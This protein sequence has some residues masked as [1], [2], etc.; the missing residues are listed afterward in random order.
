VLARSHRCNL[1]LRLSCPK[2]SVRMSGAPNSQ[3]LPGVAGHV[4]ISEREPRIASAAGEKKARGRKGRERWWGRSHRRVLR[5]RPAGLVSGATP[6]PT[7]IPISH[8][9][10]IAFPFTGS[11]RAMSGSRDTLFCWPSVESLRGPD[12]VSHSLLHGDAASETSAY[13]GPKIAVGQEPRL[14]A[15]VCGGRSPSSNGGARQG[16]RA[17]APS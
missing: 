4:E 2:K 15:G 11:Q 1:C 16:E 5:D 8:A 6:S 12:L 9:S 3:V 7:P 14:E 10:F 13:S 17:R